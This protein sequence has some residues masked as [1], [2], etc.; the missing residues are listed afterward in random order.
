M[1]DYVL[2][3]VASRELMQTYIIQGCELCHRGQGVT[4]RSSRPHTAFFGLGLLSAYL[5]RTMLCEGTVAEMFYH[6]PLLYSN[7][8]F[9]L[10]IQV[11]ASVKFSMNFVYS[12]SA[13]I[14]SREIMKKYRYKCV[15]IYFTTKHVL[16]KGWCLL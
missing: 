3:H 15:Y 12:C 16:R 13:I 11:F 8:R 7:K 1:F 2:H 9:L 4:S 6:R 14:V 5:F 10:S